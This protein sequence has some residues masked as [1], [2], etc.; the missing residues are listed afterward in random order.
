MKIL[1]LLTL[2]A[3]LQAADTCWVSGSGPTYWKVCVSDIGRVTK[4][5]SPQGVSHMA[6]GTGAIEG[7]TLTNLVCPKDAG[8]DWNGFSQ[9]DCTWTKINA[10]PLTLRGKCDPFEVTQVFTRDTV[11]RELTIDHT[12]KYAFPILEELSILRRSVDL[13][14]STPPTEP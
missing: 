10:S 4:F 11:R 5:E 8:C 3:S 14:T 1:V 7:F 9:E 6:Q 2:A 13:P 12:F